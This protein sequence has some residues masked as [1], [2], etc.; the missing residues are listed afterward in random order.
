M[1][2]IALVMT[3]IVILLS[4]LL[5][6]CVGG[7]SQEQ[8]DGIASQLTK[9]KEQLAKFQDEAQ[10]L[11]D[12]A[13]NL[14][15]QKEAVAAELKVAQAKVALLESQVSGLKEQ[16]ELVGA[17][18]AET[19]ENIVRYY[20]ETHVY[21]TYDLFVCSDMAAEVWNMLK[22]QGINSRIVVGSK[23]TAIADIVQSD[24]AW[25]LAEVAPGD[26]LALETTGG[27]VVPESENPLY[28][29]G[30]YFNSPKDL[31]SNNNLVREYNVR[32]DIHN[33]IVNEANVVHE[34][35]EQAVDKYNELV[36][37]YNASGGSPAL[38]E[39]IEAQSN[40]VDKEEAVYQ[41]LVELVEAQEAEMEDIHA[42]INSLATKCGT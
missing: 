6:G 7:I 11:Q 16:Y 17:T 21:S 42:E 40:I 32:V 38:E 25:V 3:T 28:Y 5:V 22:A 9:A 26:Y 18:P 14:L 29:R 39:Q 27:F 24:H 2:K 30:W 34:R 13:Q 10:N 20:H 31:K 12:E 37:E 36:D 15:A 19:A 41:R 33:Q 8:Y 1:R 23:D 35:Y 4:F